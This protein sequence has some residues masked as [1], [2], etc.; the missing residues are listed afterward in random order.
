MNNNSQFW[1]TY[2]KE[3]NIKLIELCN[4]KEDLYI[5]LHIHSNYSSDGKQTIKQIINSTN[6]KKFDVIAITDHDSVSAYEELYEF[7]KDGFTKPLII[8]G[9]E[10]TMDNREYGNQCHI[11]QLFINPKDKILLSDVKKNYDAAFNR[12]KIQFKRLKDNLAIVEL[13]KKHKIRISYQEYI[14]YLNENE[15]VPE[16]DTL[17][18]YIMDKFKEKGITTFDVLNL[19]EKYNK[20]DCYKDRKLFKEKRY[21]KLREKYCETE[22]NYFNTRFLLSMLAVREVDDD[23]WNKPSSGSLSV[24]SYGQLKIEDLN[25]KFTTIFAHPTESKLNVVEDILKTKTSIIGLEKNIRNEY[26]DSSNFDKLIEKNKLI[27]I[28]GSDSHDD[29]LV[30][31]DNMEFFK[32]KSSEFLK[33]IS[34]D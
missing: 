31:Y 25:T 27:R 11:L 18:N 5:D 30:F 19:L 28:M 8:P 33:I 4:K 2:L 12:S 22:N 15:M 24:N 20:K 32:I 9:I 29:S 17:C 16:Y 1:K 26:K 14:N 21:K 34:G 13:L 6:K 3:L 23:W 10:F 7:V